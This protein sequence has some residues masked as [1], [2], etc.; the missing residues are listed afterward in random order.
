MP[1]K[2]SYPYSLALALAAGGALPFAYAPSGL[3]YIAPLSYAALFYSWRGLT[4]RRA[5]WAGLSFGGASFFAGV[6]WVY[7]S[8]HDFGQAPI[9][10]AVFL[11]IALVA[12]LALFVAV[13][14][15]AAAYWFSTDG[16]AAWFGVLPALWVLTEWWRGWFL[17]G[18]GWLAAGYSQTDSWLMG[19]APVAGVYAISWAVLLTAGALVALGS[20]T[21]RARIGAAAVIGVLWLGGFALGE[22]RWTEAKGTVRTVALVQ[23]AVAQDLKWRPEQRRP[24][25]D[26]YRSLTHASEGSALIIWPEAAIP[27]LY[28]Q[29]TD[30]LRDIRI[31]AEQRSSAVMTGIL[32][33]DPGGG[34][35]QNTLVV[36]SDPPAFYVKRHLVPYGEYFP[37]PGFVRSWMRLM[38]LPYTDAVPGDAKQPPLSVAGEKI[39]V[40]ICYEDVFGAEQL[41]YLPDATLLVNVSNDA[42]FGDSIAPHQHLQI[43]R[44]RAAETGRYLLRA[45]NTGVSAIIDPQGRIVGRSPQFEPHVLRGAVQGYTG[46][47]P[48]A[49][50]GNYAV[51]LG[52]LA[53]IMLQ[54]LITKFTIRPGT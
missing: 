5:F 10:L 44:V 35:F 33:D 37:V 30:Y 8:V 54:L 24:T 31:W 6:H 11:T 34:T 29:V 43:S 38:S 40:T 16:P 17:G 13:A 22:H 19:Y 23:A 26:L 53:V 9:A 32:R 36:L 14:G 3:F 4:P 28:E 47:T 25:L 46:V 45:T 39:G 15:W 2:L 42:W 48:Y 51:V 49:R 52:A 50:W 41:H 1:V 20:G 21:M 12:I 27:A 18:F 7:V